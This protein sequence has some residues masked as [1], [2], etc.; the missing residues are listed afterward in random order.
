VNGTAP[1][2]SAAGGSAALGSSTV[3]CAEWT[4]A[5][6]LDPVGTA[7]DYAGYLLVDWPLPWPRDVG[8]IEALAAL[9]P[10]LDA[11]GCRLQALVAPGDAA[12]RRVIHYHRHPD[13]PFRGFTR[14]EVLVP[15][16][17]VVD[18][19]AEL[20]ETRPSSA[21]EETGDQ[22]EATEHVV[23]VCT[24]GRRDRCCGAMGTDLALG[25]L[26]DPRQLGPGTR[27]ARTS[28]TGGHRYAPTAVVFPEG[29]AWAFADPALLATVVGRQGPVADVL[30]HYRGCAGVGGPTLQVIERAV[31]GE[32]GWAL[33]DLPRRGED[34]GDGR[35]R[36]HVE[37]LDGP[38]RV[39]TWEATV[40]PG[41]TLPMPDCGGP[42][43]EAV[44]TARELAIHDFRRVA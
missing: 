4:L 41:R 20:L 11:A 29:T 33:F 31:L 26:A 7:G 24:H 3:R 19:A 16:S 14:R 28:H 8:E 13:G 39:A 38:G 42:V 34:L 43:A 37:G 10:A 36:L 6:G 32:V 21:P 35:V 17:E 15:A 44:A 9:R 25:L 2:P 12:G 27:V 5:Q 30:P 18:A 40:A 1:Q 22:V 23:I